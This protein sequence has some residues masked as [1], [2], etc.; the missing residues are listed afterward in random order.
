[1]RIF[2]PNLTVRECVGLLLSHYY[3]RE[4][5]VLSRSRPPRYDYGLFI[6]LSLVLFRFLPFCT[7]RQF[8]VQVQRL[9]ANRVK[10]LS[11]HPSATYEELKA[12]PTTTG[13]FELFIFDII[14]SII[15]SFHYTVSFHIMLMGKNMTDMMYW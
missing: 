10:V 11:I 7:E 4:C 6:L 5:I 13:L 15:P 2:H 3:Y 14:F 1:M 8:R 12:E 9:P